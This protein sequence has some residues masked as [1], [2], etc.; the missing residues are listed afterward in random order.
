MTEILP[1]AKT[2]GWLDWYADSCAATQAAGRKSDAALLAG[3]MLKKH[4]RPAV[5]VQPER[6]YTNGH[7]QWPSSPG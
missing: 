5:E 2:P 6:T 1:F 3:T 7:R 4:G